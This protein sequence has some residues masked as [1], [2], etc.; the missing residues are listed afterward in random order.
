MFLQHPL[1][2]FL[3]LSS[4]PS[5][6]LLARGCCR[7]HTPSWQQ[8]TFRIAHVNTSMCYNM[9]R[10]LRAQHEA[11]GCF[12]GSDVRNW[13]YVK[14]SSTGGLNEKCQDSHETQKM[15]KYDFLQLKMVWPVRSLLCHLKRSVVQHVTLY[16]SSPLLCSFVQISSTVQVGALGVVSMDTKQLAWIQNR[17]WRVAYLE[18]L[19]ARK[20]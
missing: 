5:V 12:S 16:L 17:T 7:P 1:T 10:L 20:S 4:S 3:S 11:G 18:A 6:S 19:G 8:F 2:V 9:S 14:Y 13:K 15:L